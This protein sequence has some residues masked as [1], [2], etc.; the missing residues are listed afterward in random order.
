M[1]LST[2]TSIRESPTSD[3]LVFA[4]LLLPLRPPLEFSHYSAAP[5]AF[6]FT[7]L[8]PSVEPTSSLTSLLSANKTFPI[9]CC[10]RTLLVSLQ[11]WRDFESKVS[12]LVK[13]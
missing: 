11:T 4:M 10:S 12:A 7:F 3:T 8:S 13:S 6:E 9:T 1:L 2:S 5:K